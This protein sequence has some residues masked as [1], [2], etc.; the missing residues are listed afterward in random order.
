M[1]VHKC[2]DGGKPGYKWGKE[3]KCYTYTP[4]SESSRKAAKKKA[5]KQGMAVEGDK[6]SQKANLGLT[7]D[8]V[9]LA[10]EAVAEWVFEQNLSRVDKIAKF[11]ELNVAIERSVKKEE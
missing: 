3:G 8:D 7:E 9:H 11:M 10:Q 1:P 4:K 2:Q 6:F 5:L